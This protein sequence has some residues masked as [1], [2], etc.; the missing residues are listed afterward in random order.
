MP[1]IISPPEQRV[2][3]RNVSW[4]TYERLV[5]DLRNQSTTRLTYDK[6]LLEIMSPLPEH[7]KYNRTISLLIEIIAIELGINIE[8]FGSTTFNREDLERG[9]E[10]D[11]CFYIQNANKIKGKSRIDLTID[12]PPDLVIEIDITNPSLN[13]FPIYAQV[14]VPEIWRYDGE[15]LSIFQL[16]D[17][18]YITVGK[19]AALPIVTVKA[20]SGFLEESKS[21]SRIE[22]IANLR[23]WL[24]AQTTS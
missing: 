22:M 2:I 24:G 16:M 14:G 20:I 19:S 15:E 10:P 11:S 6:G 4:N 1:A 13:K 9:F 17:D 18:K 7:E 5:A 23:N 3:L 21:L 12:P 8:N